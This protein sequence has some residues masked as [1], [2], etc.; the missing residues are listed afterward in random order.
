[1]AA[2]I[3]TAKGEYKIEYA[4]FPTVENI[5]QEVNDG[6]SIVK[7]FYGKRW[8][9]FNIKSKKEIFNYSFLSEHKFFIFVYQNESSFLIDENFWIRSIEIKTENGISGL[10]ELNYE[11]SI[12]FQD[13]SIFNIDSLD[14]KIFKNKKQISSVMK[15][16]L[17][18]SRIKI[19]ENN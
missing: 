10:K 5:W 13:P 2:K 18:K 3:I 12:V 4:E 17:A 15:K 9:D 11:Y 1:M 14:L 6:L 8:S 19:Y 7:L 16:Y